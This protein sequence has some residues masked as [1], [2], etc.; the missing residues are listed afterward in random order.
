MLT[1][2]QMLWVILNR[3]MCV[4]PHKYVSFIRDSLFENNLQRKNDNLHKTPKTKL[5]WEHDTNCTK[6]D[7]AWHANA[8]GHTKALYMLF[9]TQKRL[10]Y[11]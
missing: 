11:S 8:M 1:D 4:L 9:T 5:M 7:N 3:Y 6:T 2:M 10:V